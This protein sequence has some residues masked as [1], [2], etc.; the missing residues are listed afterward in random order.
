MEVTQ[1][2]GANAIVICAIIYYGIDNLFILTDELLLFKFSF[3]KE[4]S[5]QF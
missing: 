4:L 2:F 5:I 3:I 1:I